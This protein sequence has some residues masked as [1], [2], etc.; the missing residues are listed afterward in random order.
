MQSIV[1]GRYREAIQAWRAIIHE[2][3]E[4]MKKNCNERKK[5]GQTDA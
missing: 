1:N 3:D 5:N 2:E 4:E